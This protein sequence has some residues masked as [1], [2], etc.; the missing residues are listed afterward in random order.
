MVPRR[1]ERVLAQ[2]AVRA[3]SPVRERLGGRPLPSVVR[4]RL[5]ETRN[6]GQLVVER[7][8]L[9]EDRYLWV[10]NTGIG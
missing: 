3:P 4:H 5:F 10:N 9:R 1:H 8:L 7:S 6:I 2:V